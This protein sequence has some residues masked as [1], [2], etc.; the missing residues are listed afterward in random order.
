MGLFGTVINIT[1]LVKAKEL[2]KRICMEEK[3]S[4]KLGVIDRDKRRRNC[5]ALH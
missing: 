4:R 5:T 3:R 1:A 2:C